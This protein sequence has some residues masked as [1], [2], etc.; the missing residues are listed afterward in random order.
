MPTEKKKTNPFKPADILVSRTDER[1]VIRSANAAFQRVSG[2]PWE[3]LRNAPHKL[4]RHP[5]TPKGVFWQIWKTLQEGEP[6]GAF[7]KNKDLNGESYWVFA[8]ATPLQDGFFSC[9]MMPSGEMFDTVKSLYAEMLALEAKD[10]CTPEQSADFL[11]ER[12]KE[13]GYDTY[14]AFMSAAIADQT[15]LRNKTLKRPPEKCVLHL[16]ECQKHWEVL[17]EEMNNTINSFQIFE[18]LP[19]NMRIQA[20]Q[21]GTEGIPLSIIAGNFGKM[22]DSIEA[23]AN[24]FLEGGLG[25]E[26]KIQSGKLLIGVERVQ[27]EVAEISAKEKADFEGIDFAEEA[28]FMRDQN[29]HYRAIAQK[30]LNEVLLQIDDFSDMFDAVKTFYTGISVTRVM[31]DIEIGQVTTLATSSLSAIV[32]E[33]EG[34]LNTEG[35]RLSR[36]SAALKQIRLEIR[37]TLAEV[38]RNS[39]KTLPLKGQATSRQRHTLEQTTS[40]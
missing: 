2:Y 28:R 23:L 3:E 6:I 12:L 10:E 39:R 32:E 20:A 37:R 29:D 30:S 25:L 11:L 31:A 13:R 33:L 38:A 8:V 26:M 17:K 22:T 19:V 27:T 14:R 34:F 7:F 24:Q 5:E 36:M 16:M 40:P 35:Q 1:G 4:V 9:Q 18:K 21:L 15:T